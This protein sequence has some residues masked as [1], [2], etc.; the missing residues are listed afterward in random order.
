MTDANYYINKFMVLML[1]QEFIRAIN[2]PFLYVLYYFI[3][4]GYG[5][6]VVS[7]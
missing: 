1:C 5:E 7:L 4:V 6:I 3:C 2:Y